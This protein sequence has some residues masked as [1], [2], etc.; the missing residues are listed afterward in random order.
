MRLWWLRLHLRYVYT[1]PETRTQLTATQFRRML[2]SWNP[3][4]DPA[5]FVTT[6]RPWRGILKIAMSEDSKPEMQLDAYGTRTV[7]T[8]PPT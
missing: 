6:F 1:H 8:A 7:S 4:E 2:A 5:A 3:L